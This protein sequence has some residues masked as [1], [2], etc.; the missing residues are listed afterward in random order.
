MIHLHDYKN[1]G[2]KSKFKNCLTFNQ[3][4]TLIMGDGIIKFL[5]YKMPSQHN[6]F[7]TQ[8]NMFETSKTNSLSVKQSEKGTD[9]QI[10]EPQK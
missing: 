9:H 8:W 7:G 6:T 3:N 2:C 10:I 4:D 5:P 1:V